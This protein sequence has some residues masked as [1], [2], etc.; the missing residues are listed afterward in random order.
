MTYLLDTCIVSKLRKKTRDPKL[1]EWIKKHP[2]SH[3]ALSSLTIGEIQAGISQLNDRNEVKKH[4]GEWLLGDLIPSFEGRILEF[5]RK[6]V[7]RWGMLLGECRRQGI[8]LPIVD[9]QIAAVA[10]QHEL[11]LVTENIKDFLHTGVITVNPM[12]G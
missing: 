1:E 7:I 8:N 3:Y 10:L 12:V 11:I 6:V 9:S 4:L 5:D 2:A